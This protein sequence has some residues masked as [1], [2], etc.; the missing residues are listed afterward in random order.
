M[1]DKGN[2]K[3]R[4]PMKVKKKKVLTSDLIAGRNNQNPWPD[5]QF[6]RHTWRLFS[7]FKPIVSST[8][9]FPSW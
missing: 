8:F 5:R 1:R 4:F 6:L 3:F 9:L 7:Q 2:S